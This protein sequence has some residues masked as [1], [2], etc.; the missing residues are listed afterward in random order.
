M[1]KNKLW[2]TWLEVTEICLWTMTWGYQNTEEEAHE[3]LDYAIKEAWINFIDTAE[4]YAIPPMKET[5]W[6]TEKYIWTW[7]AKN[8]EL[9]SEI[10]IASK[11]AGI[12]LPWIRDGKWLIAEDMEEAVNGSLERMQTTYIDLYQL[13]WPQRQVNKFGKMNYD[14]NMFTSK[15]EEEDHILAILQAFEALRKQ[16]KVKFLGL[17]NE[18]P[19]GI[20][21]FLEIA[22]K[23]NL[24]KIQ[25]NQNAYSLVQR[26]Y[27]V[28]LSEVSLFENIG[29]LAYSPLAWWISHLKISRLSTS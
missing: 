8:Q 11:M 24:P 22:E 20:M 5:Q 15:Q 4:L 17:S 6:L 25:T 28:W 14:D 21:K 13:H 29:L 12:W 10:I 16:G 19:W 18:T 9:R 26:Q 1:K 2:N 23:H 3:Q 27:E 7:M